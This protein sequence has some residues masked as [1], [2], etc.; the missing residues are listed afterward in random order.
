MTLVPPLPLQHSY[1]DALAGDVQY[2]YLLKSSTVNSIQD[3]RVLSSCHITLALRVPTCIPS[4]LSSIANH[5]ILPPS[6]DFPF[7]SPL[8]HSLQID[9]FLCC[10]KNKQQFRHAEQ[11]TLEVTI[12]HLRGEETN[13][14]HLGFLWAL[15]YLLQ[16]ERRSVL[17]TFLHT[18]TTSGKTQYQVQLPG[19]YACP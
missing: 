17:V 11:H 7:L 9:F 13:P 3:K 12:L 5:K 6:S 16:W 19:T 4:C 1:K 14:K 15:H 2:F 8:S 10:H 18:T